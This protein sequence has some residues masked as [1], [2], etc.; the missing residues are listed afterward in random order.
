MPHNFDTVDNCLRYTRDSVC[1]VVNITNNEK[2]IGYIGSSDNHPVATLASGARKILND[3]ISNYEFSPPLTGYIQHQ[4]SAIYVTR[5]PRRM[6]KVGLARGNSGGLLEN[7]GILEVMQG[8]ERLDN[9]VY[10]H[11]EEA[12]RNILKNRKSSYS[13]SRRYAVSNN[14]LLHCNKKVAE[15]NIQRKTLIF[16]DEN[17]LNFHRNNLMSYG[18]N[19]YSWDVVKMYD[20]DMRA[21]NYDYDV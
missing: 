10:T 15:L 5:V 14:A 13:V 19:L 20:I 21:Y 7:Y 12:E 2:F 9:R 8:L 1:K 6:W 16:A 11:I 3:K 18:F 4:N 17:S